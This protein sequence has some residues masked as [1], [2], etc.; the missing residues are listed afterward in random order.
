MWYNVDMEKKIEIR[1]T[2]K[3]DLDQLP[4]LYR[5]SYNGDTKI[6]TNYEGMIKE[7]EKLMSNE[8]YKFVSAMHE[9]KLVGFC[10]VVV[11]HDIVEKQKPILMLWNLRVHPEYRKQNIGKSIIAFIEEFGRSI[12]AYITLLICNKENQGAI[13]FYNK[14][15][16]CEHCAF[17]K[18]ILED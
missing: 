3:S 12:D 9:G 15:G 6:E 11:N 13:N 1:Y 8:D 14:L 10:S 16:F 5:Q 7:Y 2:I 17:Y 4:W 18:D